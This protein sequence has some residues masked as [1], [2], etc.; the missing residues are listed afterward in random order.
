[1]PDGT[2][3]VFGKCLEVHNSGTAS[4]TPVDINTCNGSAGQ[5]WRMAPKGPIGSELINPHSGLCL[6]DPGD[7]ATNGT[8]LVIESCPAPPDPGTSWHPMG[9]TGGRRRAPGGR[10]AFRSLRYRRPARR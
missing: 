2:I 4:L 10:A 1:M 5:S 9:P 7:S 8:R 3:R 6:A